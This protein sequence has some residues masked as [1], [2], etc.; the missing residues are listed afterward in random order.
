MALFFTFGYI[1]NIH[2]DDIKWKEGKQEGG[3]CAH[4]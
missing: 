3:A 1:Y 2:E 4:V